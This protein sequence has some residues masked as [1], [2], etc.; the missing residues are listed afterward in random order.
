MTE[1]A[2]TDILFLGDIHGRPYWKNIIEWE[3]PDKVVFLGDYVTTHDEISVTQQIRNLKDIL[4]YKD[5]DSG[6]VIMLRGHHD[7]DALAYDWAKCYPS[8]EW[9]WPRMGL[10]TILGNR[11]LESTQWCYVF[12]NNGEKWVASHAGISMPWLLEIV[13]SDENIKFQSLKDI[14]KYAPTPLF[15]FNGDRYDMCGTS[16]QQSL[17]W[18]RPRTLLKH[19]IP[20]WNQIVAHT[21]TETIPVL[22]HSEFGKDIWFCD[23]MAIPAY[24]T[25]D[26]TGV[27][28]AKRYAGEGNRFIEEFERRSIDSI[29]ED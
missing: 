8:A 15:G 11:F 25:L 13:N 14:N 3:Q 21:P 20:H 9:L 29:F 17:T 4:D 2:K 10:G 1:G 19:A 6:N 24:L 18:I 28:H 26:T 5:S 27:F 22:G 23:S 16:P 12:E 7:L